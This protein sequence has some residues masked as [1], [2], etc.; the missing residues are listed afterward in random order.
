MAKVKVCVCYDHQDD[1]QYR[2][3]LEAWD[4]NRNVDFALTSLTPEEVNS[5]NYSVIQGVLTKHITEATRL[6]VIV[7]RHA[8]RRHPRWSEIG[9]RNWIYWEVN[10]AKD[11]GKKLVGVKLD[12]SFDS[13]E[14]LLGSG[15]SWAM[16]FNL[17]AIVDALRK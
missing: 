4:A 5:D 17:D 11:L 12:R 1:Q 7:G 2:R 3:L 8:T 14:P 10:K 16:S 13:P 9:D 15:A 6:L